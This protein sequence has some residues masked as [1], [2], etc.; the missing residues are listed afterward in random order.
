MPERPNY[1]LGYGERLVEPVTVS[2]AGGPKKLP[3]TFDQARTWLLPR[4]R[5]AV[6]AIDG[7]ST[8]AC[9][10]D[11]TVALLTL[12]PAFI[13]KSYYPDAFLRSFGLTPVGSRPRREFKPRT[14][15]WKKPPEFEETT[16]LFVAGTRTAFRSLASRIDQVSPSDVATREIV[17]IEDFRALTAAERVRPLVSK[18]DKPLLEVVLHATAEDFY[19]LEG[20]KE[21]LGGLRIEVHLDRRFE[22]EGLCFLP[23][24]APRESVSKIAEFSFLRV[25]REMPHLRQLQP[26]LRA[27]PGKTP[28]HPI[29]PTA[30]PV[31]PNLRVA[32]FDGGVPS[33][34]AL[35]PW[36]SSQSAGPL[37]AEVP[38][39]VEHGLAVSSALLFGSLKDQTVAPQP[40]A[41]VDHF[42]VLDVDTGK[43]D[44]PELYSVLT[45]I[46]DVLQ[47]KRYAFVNLSI[48]PDLPVEDD[49]VHAWTAVLDQLLADGTT[50]LSIAAGNGGELDRAAGLARIQSPA[51]CVNGLTVGAAD[52]QGSSWRKACYSSIGP[53]R[54]PGVVKPDI[55]AFGGSGDDPFWVVSPATP[56]EAIPIRGTSFAAPSA[57]RTALG[58][59]AHFGPVL[60]PLALKALLI[61]HADVAGQHRCEAGWGRIPEEIERYVLCSD[62]T[63]IVVYQGELL[64]G[65]WVR[66]P[67]PTPAHG[68][69]GMMTLKATFTFA[70]PTDPQDP[71]NYTRSGLEIRFRPNEKNRTDP[72]QLHPDSETF[73]QARD[74]YLREDELRMDAHKW[75]T[76][77]HKSK[78]MR[79]ERLLNPFFDVHYHARERGHDPSKAGR[80]PYGLV[81]SVDAP[82]QAHLYDE[83]LLRYRT[84]LQPLQPV[85]QIPVRV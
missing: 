53:G 77:L 42:R 23:L 16:E 30:P 52:S 51:D 82:R 75:E 62:S 58:V 68:L 4:L 72:N 55:L 40:Y 33:T 84:Q 21:F 15:T 76:T 9:P 18:A 69:H 17:K 79:G 39:V 34:S 61:H 38:G 10:N 56:G 66:V 41:F 73:F 59:R 48:G 2:K 20:F 47:R 65:Q 25:V 43:D 37:A 46:R 26:I 63:V 19:I 81:V 3:Y 1:L 24:K 49:E 54:R 78:R 83:V 36:V 50:L 8:Q 5:T 60:Q 70:T 44:R 32:V 74:H 13:A 12:H 57:L 7:L 80:I 71:I 64:P 67:I 28:I 45:R 85:I 22:A 35:D 31:D 29:L 11:E 14:S 6:Q 27:V